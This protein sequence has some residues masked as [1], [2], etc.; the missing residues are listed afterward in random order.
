[1]ETQ[2]FKNLYEKLL[3]ATIPQRF[4]LLE[5]EEM[6][7]DRENSEIW[8]D[9]MTLIIRQMMVLEKQNPN[10]TIQTR[11]LL[12]T[13]DLLHSTKSYLKANCNVRLTY[14]VFLIFL[15]KID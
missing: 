6:I 3:S 11:H 5:Q 8:L 13:L 15:P 9:K 12:K 10:R 1:M 14:E 7:K 4:F 2:T